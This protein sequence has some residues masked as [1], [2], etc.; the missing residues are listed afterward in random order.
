MF[1]KDRRGDLLLLQDR[2]GE[3]DQLFAV[4][5]R[6]IGHRSDQSGARTA[7]FFARFADRVLAHDRAEAPAS[8]LLESSQ[9]A[10]CAGGVD[11]CDQCS[12]R[13]VLA[14]VAANRM[15]TVLELAPAI[16]MDY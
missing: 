9:G 7:E 2:Q 11:G 4:A 12:L 10:Q 8:G 5:L 15:E 3:R 16:Q 6:E 1:H 14:Q 13:F